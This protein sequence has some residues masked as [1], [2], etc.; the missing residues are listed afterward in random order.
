MQHFLQSIGITRSYL[1]LNT[2]AYPIF[3][4]YTSELRW[5]AQD[6]ASPIVQ[7]RHQLL[8]YAVERNPALALVVSVGTAAKES[9]ETWKAMRGGSFPPRVRTLHMLHPG[10]AAKDDGQAAAVR[11]SFHD[12]F[13]RVMKWAI[14]AP[15]WLPVDEEASRKDSANYHFSSAAIPFRDLPFGV[16]WRLGSG[17]TVSNRRDGQKAIQIFSSSGNYNNQADRIS[18]VTSAA[19]GSQ[20]G[21]AEDSGDRPFEPPR[22]K[23]DRFDHGPGEALAHLMMGG[24][25]QHDW[26]D[27]E[28]LG[29]PAHP[30]FGFGP[31]YRGRSSHAT[32]L[33]YVDQE[34]CD[35]LF[36]AR[37]ATGKGGQYLQAFL[38]ASGWTDRYAIVRPIPVDSSGASSAVIRAVLEDRKFR[39]MHAAIFAQLTKVR[40]V[41]AV[42]PQAQSLVRALLP[43]ELPRIEMHAP[44]AAG[45][46]ANW[47]AG[48][49]T[50]A[51]LRVPRDHEVGNFNHECEQVARMD[52][53]YGTPRWWGSSGSRAL[54]AKRQGEPSRDYFKIVMP[55][56]AAEL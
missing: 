40:V 15:E 52:L 6:P 27:F 1:Y 56:W 50:L 47:K 29:L 36:T 32:L 53:P 44:A 14:E 20:E 4:Q 9:V 51:K 38:S 30:S 39:A 18:Y 37:A 46:V 49:N 13:K 41:L 25:A 22:H 16:A 31:I 17:G 10:A 55:A 35:D 45:R 26:P 48:F 42:G 8:E 3:D 54:Q 43:Q 34:S 11:A 21:Y 23:S 19:R 7:H 33:A 28:A 2:F 5:L 12:A 24:S